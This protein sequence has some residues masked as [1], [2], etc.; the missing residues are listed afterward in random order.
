MQKLW[1]ADTISRRI[2]TLAWLGLGITALVLIALIAGLVLRLERQYFVNSQRTYVIVTSALDVLENTEY[3]E[4][5]ARGYLLTGDPSYI[6]PHQGSRKDLDEEFDRLRGLVKN[7]P[8]EREQVE[9]LRYLVRQKLDELQA[10]IEVRTTARPEAARNLVRTGRSV[11]LMDAI[12]QHVSRMEEEE[13]GTLARFSRERQS[14]LRVSLAALVGSFFLA[15]C[16]L[17]IG[18]VM[19]ARSTTQR[20][21]VEEALR[22]SNSR[23][24]TLCEQAPL[25][26]YETDAA[27]RCVYTNRMWTTMSGLSASE[28]LGHGWTKVLQPDERATVF[29][30]WQ[31]AAKRGTAWE[32]RLQNTQ[33]QTR[34]I[35]A[36]GG[37]L[38]SDGGSLTGYVGTLEDVTERSQAVL[39]LKD[40]EALNRAVLNSLPANIAVLKP[41][42][43]IQATNEAWQRFAQA[44][45]AHTPGVTDTGANYLEVC[46]R[47]ATDGSEDAQKALAGIQQVLEG[48]RPTFVMQY[49]CHSPIEKR[50]FHMVV[51]RLAGAIGGA[52]IAH[53]DITQRKQAEQG[54]RLAVEAAPSG[55]VMVDRDGK[56]VLVNS[57]TEKLFGYARNELLGQP[58]EMLVPESLREKHAG[59]RTEYF[60]CALA[61]PM[62]MGRD[63]YALR[64]DGTQFP[65]EIDLNP[66]ETEQGTWVLS[67][68]TDI[69]ER[70]RAREER[71]KFVSLADRSLE[72]IGMCDLDFRWFYVNPAGL[73][74]VGLDNLEAA[75]QIKVQDYFFVED[76]PFI[77]N[78]FFPRVVRDGQGQIE[79]RFRHFKTGEAIWMLYNVF[80][81][82]DSRGAVVGWATVSVDITERRRAERSLQESRQELRAL[83]GRLIN[84]EEEE[85][86][87]I[88]RELHDDLSQKLAMLAFDTGSLVLAPPPSMDEMREPLRNL[89]ARIVQLSQHVRQISHQLHPTILE[90]LGLTAALSELCEEFS[91]R[92]GIEVAFE[93][94]AMPKNLP[95]YVASCLYRVAQEALHNVSK[96]AR[97]TRVRLK[98]SG[99]PEGFH[100]SICDTG[101]GFDSRELHQRG[102]GIV[103]MKERVGMVQGQFSIHSQPGQGT[104][105]KVFVPLS[106]GIE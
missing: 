63:L 30:G 19:L 68:I 32:Y 76:Q 75:C 13:Q 23:F 93:Q 36:V 56:I 50:W 73:R 59:L 8:K 53:V 22:A 55:M 5:R 78:E 14:R 97:A 95:V 83:A 10:A 79:I 104:E 26:I 48:L 15:G 51:T 45:G 91:A 71:Q 58:I 24:E 49:P 11:Q 34:W 21:R 7:N 81:I 106:K 80:G 4:A 12:R 70:R 20:Q 28:S 16:G 41:D 35:R 46:K 38:Y 84:A 61:R 37:P 1:R 88:S 66:I 72:F 33:G 2:W 54:F 105:V 74:L 42:G 52:V 64:K 65:V 40:S 103:S 90:D 92:E 98:I 17:L 99:S 77:T 69:T 60:S 96:H 47:A 82:C 44:N 9:K 100:L 57:R 29:E 86:K 3:A 87:R 6:E 43:K 85:R 102:L 101:I 67:S 89:Q 27:G 62:G 39:A 31:A 25:G 94:E 18:Q